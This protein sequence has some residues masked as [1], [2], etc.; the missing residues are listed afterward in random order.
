M[1]DGK[2][3]EGDAI[4]A[5]GKGMMGR[6][7]GEEVLDEPGIGDD[8]RALPDP[9]RLVRAEAGK[10]GHCP[11]LARSKG[12]QGGMSGMDEEGV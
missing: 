8:P 7:L 11:W 10:V 12:N 6:G 3:L 5:I 9:D 4:K 1:G 2:S